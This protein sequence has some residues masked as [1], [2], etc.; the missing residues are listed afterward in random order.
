MN[1]ADV[2]IVC[3]LCTSLFAGG[4]AGGKYYMDHE[5]VPVSGLS[6]EFNQRDIRDLK[7]DI[8][9]FEY[10]KDNGGLSDREQ[11]ELEQLYND[12]EDLQ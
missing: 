3:G 8:R 5:Y 1:L 9:L 11:W 4:A 7:K 10:D 6:E 2:G 12:L